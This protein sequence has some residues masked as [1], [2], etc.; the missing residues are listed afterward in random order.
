MAGILGKMIAGAAAA[1]QPVA[2]EGL[3]AEIMA[4]R[5][6][7]LQEYAQTSRVA[8]EKFTATQTD[9]ELSMK[10]RL[11]RETM[12]KT[13]RATLAGLHRDYTTQAKNV[14]MMISANGATPELL[15]EQET[16]RDNLNLVSQ[17]LTEATKRG[18]PDA[19][20]KAGA[21]SGV[22]ASRR[23]WNA[24]V[25]GKQQQVSPAEEQTKI[26]K[27]PDTP[28][29]ASEAAPGQI[30]SDIARLQQIEKILGSKDTNLWEGGLIQ[31]SREGRRYLSL[32]EKNTLERERDVLRRK[33]SAGTD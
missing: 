17:Q 4:K 27:A 30:E 32:G 26:P 9:K 13:D 7:R 24:M 21:P 22:K 12:E 20:P 33:L 15:A 31:Q 8:G 5:D 19:V 28:G 10:E 2:L 23:D 29:V 14:A 18:K 3:R 6:A 11:H 16:I 1:V 25:G